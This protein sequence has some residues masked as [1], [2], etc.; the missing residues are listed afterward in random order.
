M[1]KASKVDLL[2]HLLGPGDPGSGDVASFDVSA[3]RDRVPVQVS[4][5]A[6]SGK[7]LLFSTGFASS[8]LD[9]GALCRLFEDDH[10][11][12]RIGHPGSGRW[13]GLKALGRLFW[14][15][16]VMKMEKPV[17]YTHLTLPTIYSV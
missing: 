15:R 8:R 16:W 5:R 2:R 14:Y 10:L 4:G 12:V 6:S 1:A 11:V 13:D 7:C 3:G 9:Y 17:S